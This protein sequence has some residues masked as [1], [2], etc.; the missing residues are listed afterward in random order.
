MRRIGK[1]SGRERTRLHHSTS[2]GRGSKGFTLVEL[3]VSIGLSVLVMAMIYTAYR[4]QAGSYKAQERVVDMM[5]NARAAMLYLQR[6]IRM[7]G[8][9]P[10][11]SAGAGFVADFAA[12]YGGLG[13]ATNATGI[14]FTVDTDEDGSIESDSAEM[15]AFRLD[16]GNRLQ[17]LMIDPATLHAEWETIA[18]NIDVLDFVYL[19]G[20][21]PPNVLSPPLSAAQMAAIRSVQVTVVARSGAAP[22]PLIPVKPDTHVYS[23]QQ[24]GVLLDPGGDNFVRSALSSQILCPNLGL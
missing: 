12:P 9:D 20:A 17:R 23:N 2:P 10:A 5:Q 8:F 16:G 11:G 4:A 13:A 6:S 21:D 19:D 24:G 7:S 3:L 18:E 14:A 22:S 15:I 1:T